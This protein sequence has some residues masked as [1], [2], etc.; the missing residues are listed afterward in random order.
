MKEEN[1]Q[2]FWNYNINVLIKQQTLKQNKNFPKKYPPKS[3]GFVFFIE[4]ILPL[5][6]KISWLSNFDTD[7]RCWK[8]K[9]LINTNW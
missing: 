1:W 7:S 6:V 2:K 3:D 5:Q 8:V 9:G 4:K